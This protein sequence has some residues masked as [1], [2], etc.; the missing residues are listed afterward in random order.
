MRGT[1]LSEG[2]LDGYLTGIVIASQMIMPNQ[3]LPPILDVVLP[4]I[5][6][7]RFQR[8]M[9]LLMMRAQ[10]ASDVASVP[11]EFVASITARSKMG[12]ADW[13]GG[14][15]DA[16]SKF[17]AAWPK[18]GMM[19][20]DQRLLEIAAGELMSAELGEFAAL[21]AHRQERNLG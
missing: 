17:R 4:R 15:S 12:Q 16:V 8:F 1:D 14:F 11:D 10:A 9:D 18:K 20:E 19:K 5:D 21:V 6:P 2:W 3:W 13:A 7:S